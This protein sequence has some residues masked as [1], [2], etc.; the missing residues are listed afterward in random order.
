VPNRDNGLAAV[1]THAQT[2][3]VDA[4]AALYD[5]LNPV[6]HRYLL[7]RLRDGSDADDVAQITWMRVWDAL[8]SYTD[9][10][11]RGS[12]FRAW[13]FAVARNACTDHERAAARRPLTGDDVTGD[14]AASA[15]YE[16]DAVVEAAIRNGALRAALHGS[17]TPAQVD[18]VLLRCVAGFTAAETA[19]LTGRH[20]GAVRALQFRALHTLRRALDAAQ[21][22]DLV[23]A[24]EVVDHA[25]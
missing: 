18:V 14:R 21:T 17:L 19:A 3:D 20:P 6:L 22:A 25:S 9:R 7:W 24:T 2:G 13:L 23:A 11:D 5:L 4:F 10:G 8:G 15:K 16:P 1:V 12:G